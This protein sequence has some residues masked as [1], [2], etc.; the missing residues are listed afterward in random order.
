[1]NINVSDQTPSVC[2]IG[3]AREILYRA[4]FSARREGDYLLVYE[5]QKSGFYHNKIEG[6]DSKGQ[7]YVD[8][9]HYDDCLCYRNGILSAFGSNA[10]WME[11]VDWVE[12]LSLLQKKFAPNAKIR[13][14]PTSGRGSSQRHY[15]EE[16]MKALRNVE[17]KTEYDEIKFT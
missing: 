4:G 13:S 7:L 9:G 1:M 8:E 14:S 5:S 6:E 17:M 10:R 12:I 11:L 15:Q 3:V 16:Y 2:E